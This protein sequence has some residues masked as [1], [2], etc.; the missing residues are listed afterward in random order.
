ME[1]LSK[2][3]L[4]EMEIHGSSTKREQS[5]KDT[6]VSGV[7]DLLERKP[8]IL[9]LEPTALFGSPPP[10]KRSRNWTSLLISSMQ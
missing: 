2:L 1:Q 9:V 10:I 4:T 3:L 6:E 8:K 5:I 7:Q